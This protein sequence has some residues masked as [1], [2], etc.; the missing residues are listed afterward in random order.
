MVHEYH[1]S[2]RCNFVQETP[3]CS[4]IVNHLDYMYFLF[5]FCQTN[6][7]HNIGILVICIWCCYLFCILGTTADKFFC[8]ALTVISKE[9][10]MNENLAGVTIVAFGNGSPDIFTAIANTNSDSELMYSELL[11]AAMFVIAFVAATI[12]IVKPFRVNGQNFI[13]D[14][15]FF[16]VAVI[17]IYLCIDDGL[18]SLPE[19]IF[20]V[21]IYVIYLIVVFGSHLLLKWENKSNSNLIFKKIN[22]KCFKYFRDFRK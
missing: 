22:K 18:Y 1:I 21:F 14:C 15:L 6:L 11:G 20:T 17:C 8:P 4:D 12:I 7:A 9:L 19:A 3:E 10:R 13:T 16:I 5:C 2:E